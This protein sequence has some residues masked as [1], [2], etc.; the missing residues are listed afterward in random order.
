M[1]RI[2]VK[3]PVEVKG[4]TAIRVR[5]TN[6]EQNGTKVRMATA[7]TENGA[8]LCHDLKLSS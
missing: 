5:I 8:L 2:G 7:D 6:M 1:T 4:A 3:D